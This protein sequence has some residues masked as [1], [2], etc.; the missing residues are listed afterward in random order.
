MNFKKT[1]V[2][3]VIQKNTLFK[4]IYELRKISE[5]KFMKKNFLKKNIAQVIAAA[6]LVL[7]VTVPVAAATNEMS[8]EVVRG[9]SPYHS[10]SDLQLHSGVITYT[11]SYPCTSREAAVKLNM[12]TYNNNSTISDA[13]FNVATYA[14]GSS[15][16]ITP[17]KLISRDNTVLFSS[18]A[19]YPSESIRAGFSR[20]DI[21]GVYYLSG[22]FYYNGLN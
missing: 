20:D 4:L 11:S 14:A 2:F 19:N 15:N 22:R 13:T 21:N 10:F 1:G 7:S 16:P 5:V 6:V 18:A 17:Y 8:N 3:I 12:V 9:S